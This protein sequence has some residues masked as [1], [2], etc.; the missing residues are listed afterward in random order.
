MHSSNRATV[1][2]RQSALMRWL[3]LAVVVVYAFR[4]LGLAL[5]RAP[6]P[7]ELQSL[8]NAFDLSR[9]LRLYLDFWDNHGP[10]LTWLLAP[11]LHWWPDDHNVF[12]VA[13]M[14]AWGMAML[15]ALLVYKCAQVAFPSSRIVAPLAAL[16]FV[17]STPVMAHGIEIRPDNCVLLL[18]AGCL[19]ALIHGIRSGRGRW[20]MVAGLLLGCCAVFTIKVLPLCVCVILL[21]AGACWIRRYQA[22]EKSPAFD[23][24][25]VRN[26]L[27]FASAF[28]LPVAVLLG[29]MWLSGSLEAW[30]LCVIQANV[31]RQER[32]GLSPFT[33]LFEGAPI[34]IGLSFASIGLALRRWIGGRAGAELL[35]VG[36][37]AFLLFQFAFLLPTKF[38]SS[39]LSAQ[40]PQAILSAW[41]VCELASKVAARAPEPLRWLAAQS[42]LRRVSVAAVFAVLAFAMRWEWQ[43]EEVRYG[44]FY[45]TEGVAYV[46]FA[47]DVAGRFGRG[48]T[49]FDPSGYVFLRE[50]PGLFHI[51]VTF[52]RRMHSEGFIDLQ[53]PAL[54]RS[55]NCK[56]VIYDARANSLRPRDVAYLRS[57]F[58]PVDQVT[59]A[60]QPAVLAIAGHRSSPSGQTSAPISAV[61][62]AHWKLGTRWQR[63]PLGFHSA[64]NSI[65]MPPNVWLL[66]A[67]NRPRSAPPAQITGWSAFKEAGSEERPGREAA[68]AWFTRYKAIAV[69]R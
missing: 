68:P 6:N 58:V 45:N 59:I 39:L 23:R 48:E 49:G 34:W 10:A 67:D 5:H 46:K 20:W 12:F 50:K 22:D 7:D 38:L 63:T 44:R 69:E 27:M 41:F 24:P 57:H 60:K 14:V 65:G 15:T 64:G 37:A 55:S 17:V 33:E 3:I 29:W 9:G 66:A 56:Y 47:N 2:T 21:F 40:V 35:L 62:A 61:Y 43:R 26:L 28:S 52:I 25:S 19:L 18:W 51:L 30:Y 53:I 1:G 4:Y 16:L 31:D 8:V 32:A 13:R 42:M 54:L 11:L 36:P